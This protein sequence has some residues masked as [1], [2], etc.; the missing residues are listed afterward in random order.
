MQLKAN[1]TASWVMKSGCSLKSSIHVILLLV[2]IGTAKI[3]IHLLIPSCDVT[4]ILVPK[5][6]LPWEAS[7]ALLASSGLWEEAYEM[8]TKSLHFLLSC[9]AS[10][11]SEFQSYQRH[12]KWILCGAK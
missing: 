8:L 2:Q 9:G 10:I 3:A 4:L 7:K 12:Q 11:P 6:I 5:N 1:F